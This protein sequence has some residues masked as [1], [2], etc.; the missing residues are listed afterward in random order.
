MND[1]Q[2]GILALLKSAVTGEKAGLPVGFVLDDAGSFISRQQLCTL[3]YT[4]C[5]NSGLSNSSP[6]ARMLFKQ[7]C[8]HL[9]YSE[10]QLQA[11]EAVFSAFDSEG[12]DYL[13]LKG[14][15]MKALY[16][17]QELRWMSDADVLIRIEQ[18]HRIQPI[19]RRLG[20]AEQIES[21]HEFIWNSD[22]LHIELHKRLIPSYNK[23]Y[24]AYFGD[25]WRLAKPLH[26]TRYGLSTED[27]FIFQFVHFAKHYRDG[28][29]GCRY[30]LDLWIYRRAY[31]E[32]DE[33]YIRTELEK[34]QLLA[35]YDN[36]IQLIAVWFENAVPNE[37]TDFITDFIFKGGSWGN[38]KDHMLSMEVRKAPSQEGIK[39]SK[40]DMARRMAFPR[41]KEI[42]YRYAVL[43]KAPIL[44]PLI[45]PVRWIDVILFRRKKLLAKHRELQFVNSQRATDFQRALHYVGLDFNF[46]D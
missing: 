35:F 6:I 43:K 25:G 1:F 42:E 12:I 23:D 7:H 24:H 15:I 11:C 27:T 44:L 31:P 10:R 21:D 41:A 29:A 13:P 9:L 26:G 18:Y 28:G 3:I 16:P 2:I 33:Q 40:L 20:F 46:D 4:G 32:M 38:Q 45:W 36:I 8:Q 22:Q 14:C 39:I 30:V 19:L 5:I 17:R 37:K 34:M